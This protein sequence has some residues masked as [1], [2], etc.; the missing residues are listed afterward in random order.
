M[1]AS[2]E[3]LIVWQEAV[4]SAG[5]AGY[6]RVCNSGIRLAQRGRGS[7]LCAPCALGA[8]YLGVSYTDGETSA[9]VSK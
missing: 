1:H 9:F 5:V 4:P 8:F 2:R 3:L 6:E 7:P